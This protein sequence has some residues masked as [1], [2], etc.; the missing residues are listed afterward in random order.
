MRKTGKEGRLYLP[1]IE[2]SL[3]GR[4]IDPQDMQRP[5]LLFSDEQGEGF[6]QAVFQTLPVYKLTRRFWNMILFE[7]PRKCDGFLMPF[8]ASSSFPIMRMEMFLKSCL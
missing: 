8:W 4:E 1:S 6:A 3:S 7:R 5:A 2:D